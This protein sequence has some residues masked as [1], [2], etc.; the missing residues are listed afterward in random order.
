MLL[1]LVR[2]APVRSRCCC[3]AAFRFYCVDRTVP[4]DLAHGGTVPADRPALN[5]AATVLFRFVPYMALQ[6]LYSLKL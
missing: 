2:R 3:L 6:Q 5:N 1:L 4:S